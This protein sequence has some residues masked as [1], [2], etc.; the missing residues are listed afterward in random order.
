MSKVLENKWIT[1]NY[2]LLQTDLKCNCEPGQFFMLRSWNNFPLLSRPISIFDINSSGAVFLYEVIGEGTKILS[3]L[4]SGDSIEVHGPYGVGFP[5]LDSDVV[6][7]GGGVGVAPFYYTAKKYLDN[8]KK[9]DLYIGEDEVS[10]LEVLFQDL[11][12]NL[13]VKKSGFITDIVE[14]GTTPIL[15]CGPEIMMEKIYRQFKG[16]REVY[17]SIDKRMGCG[18]GACL[19]C[20]VK[21]VDGFKRSCKDGPVFK[22]EYVWEE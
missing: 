21:T 22:G 13:F 20:T 19:C 4:A 11:D 14:D 5:I 12:V 15:T 17:A 1:K 9:V 16:K 3:N 2:Y 7:V 18:V 6:L 8:G 10:E